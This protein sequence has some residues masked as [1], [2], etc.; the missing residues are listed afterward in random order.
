[1]REL[2][3]G[4]YFGQP[5]E[6]RHGAD[7]REAVDTLLYTEGEIVR[8]MRSAFELARQRRKK[9][10][11]VDKANILSSSRLWRQVAHEV[12]EEYPDV[13]IRGHAGRCDGDASAAPPA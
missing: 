5:S 2:T 9:L 8:L 7:G 4:I 13:G 12:R 11:S 1:M 10:T 3:G 6:Q